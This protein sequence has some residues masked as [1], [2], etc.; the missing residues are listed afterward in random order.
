M[1]PVLRRAVGH[2]TWQILL[3]LAIVVSVLL[4]LALTPAP[5]EF[6]LVGAMI[7][8]SLAGVLTPAQALSGFASPGVMTIAALYI[9]VAGL[10]ETGAMAWVSQLLLRRPRSVTSAQVRLM[11]PAA[12]LSAFVNNTPVVAMF[13]PIAQEWAARYQIPISK[14]LL[15]MNNLVIL[16][17]LCTLIGT[18]TN[19]AVNGLL[20][21]TYPDAGLGLFDLAALGVPL[22]LAGFVFMLATS[23]WLLPDRKG[24]VEQ[25][26]NAREYSF[27]ARVHAGGPLVGKSIAEVGLRNLKSAYVLEIVRERHLVTAVGPDEILQGN[28]RLTLVGVVDAVKDLRRIPGLSIAEEQTFRM[29][30]ANAQRQLV[31]LVLSANSPLIGKTVR[32]TAFRSTYQAA[33]I[34]ISRD[35][36]RLPGKLGDIEFRPGDTLLVEAGPGFVQKYKYSREFLLVS[37]LQDSQPA[38]FKRAPLAVVIVLGMMVA[39]GFE[40]V[41]LFEASF[42]AAGLMV[43]TRCITMQIATR[44]VDYAMVAGIAASFALGSALTASG[45]AKLLGDHLTGIAVGNPMLALALVYVITVVVTEIITNNAAGVL[46][47]PIAIAVA[48]FAQ[49][50]HLP[51][52]IAVMVA[53]SAGFITPIGYQTNLMV[54]GPGGYHFRDFVRLGVPLSLITGAIALWLIPQIW[55]FWGP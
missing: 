45:A 17:G 47:F 44:S 23:K 15:P 29:N 18:S 40:W 21:Q 13:I 30:L 2:V 16:A 25:L 20:V 50:N 7:V 12:G 10:R 43:L 3:T 5:T 49:V 48:E 14:L 52:V 38:D 22:T 4:T 1:R 28:D 9:V 55:P 8:L 27:E 34:S 53:A 42:I 26:E 41:P 37:P 19:L 31:E 11:L 36:S 35:G 39:A 24:A 33:I 51:F 54:Y 32:D 6:V 46:M